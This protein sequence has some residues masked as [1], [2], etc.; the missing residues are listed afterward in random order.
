MSTESESAGCLV[1]VC[2]CVIDTLCQVSQQLSYLLSLFAYQ[3]HCDSHSGSQFTI[4]IR[5]VAATVNFGGEKSYTIAPYRNKIAF[6]V[7]AV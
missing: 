1:D 7:G 4:R 5:F 3:V 6:G 2:M